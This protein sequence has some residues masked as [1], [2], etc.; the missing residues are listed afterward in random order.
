[1]WQLSALSNARAGFPGDRPLRMNSVFSSVSMPTEKAV[2]PT[3]QTLAKTHSRCTS[4]LREMNIRGETQ[5]VDLA[6]KTPSDKKRGL[7][8]GDGPSM[9]LR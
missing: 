4:R 9:T 2:D 6:A 5:R 1:M 3:G 8:E 7:T